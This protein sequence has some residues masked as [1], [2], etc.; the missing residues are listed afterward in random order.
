MSRG[1]CG[2]GADLAAICGK[3]S[4]DRA[5]LEPSVECAAARPVGRGH[6]GE[7]QRVRRRKGKFN[8]GAGLHADRHRNLRIAVALNYSR[9]HR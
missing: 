4:A 5:A 8:A 7:R 3:D 1:A 2:I 6:D 9:P